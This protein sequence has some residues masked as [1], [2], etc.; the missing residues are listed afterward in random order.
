[1]GGNPQTQFVVPCQNKPAVDAAVR[2]AQRMLAETQKRL[3][4]APMTLPEDPRLWTPAH[5]PFADIFHVEPGM[6]SMA[7]IAQ[8]KENFSLL[9]QAA[10]KMTAVCVSAAH[11][12]C[13]K[14]GQMGHNAFAV[15]EANKAPTVYLCPSFFNSPAA[16]Q[17]KTLIHELAHARLAVEHAGGR[18]LQF[19]PCG[20]SPLNSFADAIK[21]AYCYDG[22][23]E[24]VGSAAVR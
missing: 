20:K 7:Q 14:A 23:A 6:S 3:Q 13:G 8:I 15:V 5:Q 1:M 24:C 9:A 21:N 4:Q 18:Y 22:F 19:E 17:A 16:A 10:A 11:P 12:M 2:N